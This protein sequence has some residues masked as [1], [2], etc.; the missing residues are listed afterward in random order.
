M[1]TPDN[2][3][4]KKDYYKQISENPQNKEVQNNTLE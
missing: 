3:Y 4:D 2:G 1:I